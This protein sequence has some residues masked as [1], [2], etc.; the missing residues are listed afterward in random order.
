MTVERIELLERLS[1]AFGVSGSEREVM[2]EVELRLADRYAVEVDRLGN[3]IFRC[4]GTEAAPR[5]L[6]VAHADEV[7]HG[8]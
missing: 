4:G 2:N 3:R 5:I 7:A 8:K 6:L 1:C